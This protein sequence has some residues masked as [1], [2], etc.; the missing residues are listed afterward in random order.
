MSSSPRTNISFA[1]W[2]YPARIFAEVVSLSSSHVLY[3]VGKPPV[4]F[5][6]ERCC[7]R[8]PVLTTPR[9]ATSLK[10]T[11]ERHYIVV[12]FALKEGLSSMKAINSQGRGSPRTRSGDSLCSLTL[13]RSHAS[14][15]QNVAKGDYRTPLQNT[16]H[17]RRK[18][19]VRN[20]KPGLIFFRHFKKA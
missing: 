8:S 18:Q 5:S 12:Y 7:L 6:P 16:G 20:M 11:A 2:S 19:A 1:R 3:L 9:H 15:F 4:A 10:N 13:P 14:S 17:L